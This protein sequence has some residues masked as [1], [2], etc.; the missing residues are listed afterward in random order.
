MCGCFTEA[1]LSEDSLLDVVVKFAFVK[2]LALFDISRTVG[3]GGIWIP[4]IGGPVDA[5]IARGLKVTS[6]VKVVALLD[7]FWGY[8]RKPRRG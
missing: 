2:V 4:I 7:I 5:L 1:C 3:V 8:L 6:S